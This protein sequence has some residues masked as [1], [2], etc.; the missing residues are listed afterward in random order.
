MWQYVGEFVG[1]TILILLGNGVVANVLL[2]N[3]KGS[4][5]GWVVISMGWGMGVFVA[6][7]CVADLSGAH[8]NPA[9]SVGLAAA[10][11]M[12]WA[13]AAGFMV[14]QL[15]GGVLG[16]AL[17]YAFYLDHYRLTDDPD[18]KLATFCTAPNVRNT[19]QN[20]LSE[21]VAT[22]VLVFAVLMAAEPS[23]EL[24]VAPGASEGP[25]P[26]K[27][28]LG[29]IGALPV[30]LV[31][32]AIGLSL[33]G[34]TGYAINPARDLGPRIAHALLPISGKRDSDWGYSWIPVIGPVVGGLLAAL[35]HA[36]LANR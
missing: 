8:I 17:V 5:A 32:L 24:S 11:Q 14:C 1:T 19:P 3:T 21:I 28:G 30:G 25:A 22:F 26:V 34:T 12:A 29:A 6:V 35:L 18:A 15:L 4:G 20:L 10:G 36:L 31:V 27:L 16:G 33:G 9:V 23:L 13:Q 7:L 2:R